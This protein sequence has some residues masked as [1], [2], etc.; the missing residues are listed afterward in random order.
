MSG[1]APAGWYQDPGNTGQQRYWDGQ[2]WTDRI[3]PVAGASAASSSVPI[4]PEKSVALGVVLTVLFGPFA[5]FYLS[6]AYGFIAIGF[7]IL[8]VIISTFTFGIPL[9]GYWVGMIIWMVRSIKDYNAE[10]VATTSRQGLPES[11]EHVPISSNAPQTTT[12]TVHVVGE[13]LYPGLYHLP[14][15][16]RVA[17]AVTAAGGASPAANLAALNVARFLVD[18]EQIVVP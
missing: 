6:V 13:V 8:A 18:G 1:G 2:R 3:N 11:V 7:A 9:I 10:L 17:D 15:G 12:C 16:S 5:F 14:Q 4:K